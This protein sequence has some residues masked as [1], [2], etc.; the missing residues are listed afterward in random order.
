MWACLQTG[1]HCVAGGL[2]GGARPLQPAPSL[3]RPV[4]AQ[5][6]PPPSLSLSFFCFVCLQPRPARSLS[7]GTAARANV[8]IY[9]PGYLLC[10][11]VLAQ[12]AHLFLRRVRTCVGPA[13]RARG[14]E[15]IAACC[16]QSNVDVAGISY[17]DSEIYHKKHQSRIQA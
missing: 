11:A 15:G 8:A 9:F 6:S 5:P 14:R 13:T 1:G 7:S 16:V 17:F 4:R 12:L 2:R 3:A 10:L